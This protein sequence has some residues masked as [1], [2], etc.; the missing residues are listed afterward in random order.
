MDAGRFVVSSVPTGSP[1]E[2][3]GVYAGDEIVALDGFRTGDERALGERLASRRPGSAAKLLV[4]R[5]DE[6]V[7]LEVTLGERPGAWEIVADTDAGDDQKRLGRAWLGE[8]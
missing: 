8:E 2:R 4:F 7:R 3:A 5:R 1:A 6:E